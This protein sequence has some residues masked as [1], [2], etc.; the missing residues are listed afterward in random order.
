MNWRVKMA[1]SKEEYKSL[2]ENANKERSEKIKSINK[3]FALDNNTVKIGDIITDGYI[4]L[5]VEKITTFK[6]AYDEFPSC[7][8]EGVKLKKDGTPY[9]NQ[10]GNT[11]FQSRV[12]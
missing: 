3:Q 10:E 2:I 8:Y 9:K 5:K 6:S 1:M 7:M 12:L 11:I 4:T